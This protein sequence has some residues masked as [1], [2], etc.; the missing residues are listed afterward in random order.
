ML[1]STDIK[2]HVLELFVAEGLK[3]T[4]RMKQVAVEER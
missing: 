3:H 4:G 2:K 1:Q